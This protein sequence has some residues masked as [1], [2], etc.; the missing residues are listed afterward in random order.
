MKSKL[1]L[2]IVALAISLTSI[3]AQSTQVNTD[4]TVV[5]WT[6][7]KVVGSSHY[8]N[9][10]LQEG[11]LELKKGNIK[12]GEFIMQ[13]NSMTCADIDNEEYNKKLIGHLF[14]DDFFSVEQYPTA[15]LKIIEATN[16]KDNT[17]KVMAELT[18]KGQTKPVEFDVTKKDNTYISSI[19]VDRTIYGIRYGSGSFF[20]NL[21]D[22]AIDN[23]FTLDV[24]LVLK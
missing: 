1:T 21:G 11:T 18:I 3:S 14:S 16:F 23:I 19:K 8:G 10:Q 4:A 17:S 22:K 2:A 15:T 20:D 7:T 9:I 12:S 6:G 13:M 24:T 5:K